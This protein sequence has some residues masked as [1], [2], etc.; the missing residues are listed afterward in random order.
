MTWDEVKMRWPEQATQWMDQL[1]AAQDLAD[2]ELASTAKR[3]AD[4]NGKTT[5]NPGP[6]GNAAQGAIAAGRAALSDQMGEAPACLVVTPFQSGVGQGPGYQRFL[7][8]PNL[9]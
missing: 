5:T 6:V 9:L 3:L 1:S 2:G 8:A 4:L 7:S